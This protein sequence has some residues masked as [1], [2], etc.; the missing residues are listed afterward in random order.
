MTIRQAK[1]FGQQKDIRSLEREEETN[2]DDNIH[3]QRRTKNHGLEKRT[4]VTEH[5]FNC[6]NK[7]KKMHETIKIMFMPFEA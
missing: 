7:E 3:K 1:S 5:M 6:K 4:N 2:K